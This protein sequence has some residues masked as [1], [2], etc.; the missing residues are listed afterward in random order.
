MCDTKRPAPPTA[1][2][3]P[4]L[5]LPS[6]ALGQI[7]PFWLL[8]GRA[9]PSAVSRQSLAFMKVHGATQEEARDSSAGKRAWPSHYSPTTPELERLSQETES[10]YA[11]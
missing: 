4:M 7:W 8:G 6:L 9:G 5:F 11:T 3:C 2:F 10:R 1:S